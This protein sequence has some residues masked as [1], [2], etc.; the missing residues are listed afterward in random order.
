VLRCTEGVHKDALV[1]ASRQQ[2]THAPGACQWRDACSVV[3]GTWLTAVATLIRQ[4]E[5]AMLDVTTIKD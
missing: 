3:L 5:A 2:G 4:L 1:P